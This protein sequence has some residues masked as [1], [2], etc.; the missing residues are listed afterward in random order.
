MSK[1]IISILIALLG[2]IFIVV[3]IKFP[4]KDGDPGA[5]NFSGILWGFFLI[6]ASILYYLNS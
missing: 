1:L 5:L 3:T 2:I 4:E 6:I